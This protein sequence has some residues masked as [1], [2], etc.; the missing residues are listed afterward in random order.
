MN[1]GKPSGD[2]ARELKWIAEGRP[3]RQEKLDAFR[4]G[5]GDGSV[6]VGCWPPRFFCC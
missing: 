2:L 1:V 6:R 3:R 4:P 5:A